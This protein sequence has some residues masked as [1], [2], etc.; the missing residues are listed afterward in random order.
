MRFT[1]RT[2]TILAL[3]GVVA[4]LLAVAG[5]DLTSASGKGKYNSM[6]QMKTVQPCTF[7]VDLQKT[8]DKTTADPGETLTYTIPVTN[9]AE[10]SCLLD[11]DSTP[12]IDTLRVTGTYTLENRS[13]LTAGHDNN[14]C[15]LDGSGSNETCVLDVLDW[16]EYHLAGQGNT[17]H[18][19]NDA[20]CSGDGCFAE[21]ARSGNQ[22]DG[23]RNVDYYCPTNSTGAIPDLDGDTLPGGGNTTDPDKCSPATQGRYGTLEAALVDSPQSLPCGQD[24]ASSCFGEAQVYDYT[25]TVPL[26]ADQVDTLASAD[27]IRNVVHFDQ[28]NEELTSSGRN[29][30]ARSSFTY[31]SLD[32]NATGLVL[33]D[34]MPDG[35]EVVNNLG[36]LAGG[37]SVT[38]ELSYEVPADA[39]QQQPPLTDLVN[40][41]DLT[42]DIVDPMQAT[43]TT[44]VNCP[45]DYYTKRSKGCWDTP[46][47]DG[48]DAS[49]PQTIGS[50]DTGFVGGITTPARSS[51]VTN[52]TDLDKVMT[53]NP[54]QACGVLTGTSDCSPMRSDLKTQ[55]V[56]ELAAQGLAFRYNLLLL[57]SGGA[58]SLTLNDVS[59]GGVS[60]LSTIGLSGTS[61]LNQVRAK[62]NELYNGTHTSGLPATNKNMVIAMKDDL[63]VGCLNKNMAL[64][65]GDSDWDGVPEDVDNCPGG[66]NNP[67]QSDVDGD[68]IGDMCDYD[69]DGDSNGVTVSGVPVFADGAEAYMGTDSRRDCGLDAWGPDFN[70]DWTVDIFD[71]A[72]IKAHYANPAVYTARDDLSADG[73]INIVDLAVMKRFF[74]QTCAGVDPIQPGAP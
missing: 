20:S 15:K 40:S 54:V 30:F 3:V 4:F 14:P 39:C 47:C 1:R 56:R 72:E 2:L 64:V 42:G 74:F 19:L 8:V 62:L 26:T 31:A 25:L 37:A 29:H 23:Q 63:L 44:E 57:S 43:A 41:V 38:W 7:G 16:V 70:G 33:T 59:C 50:G 68:G 28:F 9:N 21:I 12:G 60:S 17:W 61:T 18:V 24:G 52:Q 32:S 6:T 46:P 11:T 69:M 53:G 48:K 49:F 22:L 51:T 35:T 27:G 5:R 73:Y 66:W 58:G 65:L 34:Q 13:S 36:D 55:H 45:Q 67:D 71:V 10:G